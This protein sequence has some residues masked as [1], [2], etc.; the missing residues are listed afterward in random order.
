MSSALTLPLDLT[1]G[2][3]L[4][5]YLRTV[6]GAPLLT[7]EEE[8]ELAR[9][10]FSENDL[11]A[12][13]Q[14]VFSHLR[15]V[16]RV[17]RGFKGYGLPL[18]DLIQEGNIGLMKAVKRFDPDRDVRLVSFA[19]HWIRSEIYDYVIRNWRIVKVATTK[20]QRKLFFNLRKSRSR[21]GWL[22]PE[23]VE[24]LAENLS[25]KEETVREMES[26][27]GAVDLSF[28]LPVDEDR[29]HRPPTPEE[30]LGDRQNDPAYL[31]AQVDSENQRQSQLSQAL[32]TLDE[33]SRGIVTRRWLQED[34]A[35]STL[36]ELAAEYGVSAERIRQI[37]KRALSD[38]RNVIESVPA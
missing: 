2:A 19:I 21:L 11:E 33:R 15:Y 36:H 7:V 25:V 38:L 9:R 3:G 29:E 35:K 8:Q 13:R 26:R 14:L 28:D 18:A 12:A 5:S 27:L 31:Y 32:A 1:A 16:V 20:A 30:I 23:E 37:E 24:E 22:K 10:Y 17:A 6:N 34:E 4:S